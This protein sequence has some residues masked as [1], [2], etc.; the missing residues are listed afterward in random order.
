MSD[1][2]AEDQALDANYRR[3][4]A[5]DAGAPA[6]ATRRAIL[7]QARV[8]S[9]TRAAALAPRRTQVPWARP[10]LFGALA[11]SVVAGLIIVPRLPVQPSP[12]AP[13][14]AVVQI[15]SA[16]SAAAPPVPQ[17]AAPAPAPAPPR[18]RAH[19]QPPP[20]APVQ[21]VRPPVA[22][23]INSPAL[24][25]GLVANPRTAIADAAT[26][27]VAAAPVA[28]LSG[29][30]LRH[31]AEVG[32]LTQLQTLSGGHPD[33]NARDASGRTALML[34]TLNGRAG[35]VAALLA[36]G[37][38]PHLADAQGVTPLAA[39]R[40]AGNA[41]IVAIFARYGLR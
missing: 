41:E 4:A 18:A 2:S 16:G 17:S 1:E 29:A 39:A 9:A 32:D 27:R 28:P 15:T 21:K 10:A 5:L 3:L 20:P 12:A 36:Y 31:A 13:A 8:L 38:D 34:A 33:L 40:A 30:Q 22:E 26:A 7:A 6:E 11:A 37:A 35:A 24:V 19:E 25:G 14:D 23:A